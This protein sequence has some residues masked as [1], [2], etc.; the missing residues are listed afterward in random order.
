MKPETIMFPNRPS[1]LEIQVIVQ[2]IHH[3][4]LLPPG[5]AAMEVN[6]YDK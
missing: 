4:Y 2:E 6:E 3:P 5:G 1:R